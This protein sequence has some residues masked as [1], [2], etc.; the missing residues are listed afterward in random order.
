MKRG[1][2]VFVIAWAM[3][4]T[5]ASCGGVAP[6]ISQM[7]LED[8]FYPGVLEIPVTGKITVLDFWASWCE[9]CKEAMP[10]LEALWQRVDR[11]EVAIVG[12]T[13][14]ESRDDAFTALEEVG[15]TVEVTFPQV[16]DSDRLVQNRFGVNT[17]PAVVILDKK[18][19]V[20]WSA[21]GLM[22]PVEKNVD[23]AQLVDTVEKEIEKLLRK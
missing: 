9:P 3:A 21:G 5:V 20:V 8:G 14:D 15:K 22:N 16:L 4:M 2:K 23:H 11:S 7:R 6:S 18:G 17:F 12:V 10:R 1:V 19:R 13:A